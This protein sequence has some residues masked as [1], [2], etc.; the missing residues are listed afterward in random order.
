LRVIY[1]LDIVTISNLYRHASAHIIGLRN[2]GFNDS[3]NSFA[4]SPS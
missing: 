2:Y 3:R 4:I 1:H